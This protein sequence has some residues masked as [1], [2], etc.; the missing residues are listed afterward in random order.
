[1]SEF[2]NLRKIGKLLAF[3][4]LVCFRISR[5]IPQLIFNNNICENIQYIVGFVFF[6]LYDVTFL[7]LWVLIMTPFC[8]HCFWLFALFNYVGAH[9]I[10]RFLT[11]HIRFLPENQQPKQCK[12]TSDNWDTDYNSYNWEPEFMTIFVTRQLGA[13]LGS[14][15]YSCIFWW[16]SQ[17]IFIRK[18]KVCA[19]SGPRTGCLVCSLSPLGS[20]RGDS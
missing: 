20:V 17:K 6:P 19:V 5:E 3:S 18:T 12:G 8:Q 2:G 13:T 10:N 9:G 7:Q 11:P 14:I 15:R 16:Q 4:C 1:M